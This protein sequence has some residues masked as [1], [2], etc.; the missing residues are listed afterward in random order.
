MLLAID[1]GNTNT[2]FGI[3]RGNGTWNACWRV[4][5]FRSTVGNDWAPTIT[6]LAHRDGIDLQAIEDVCICSVVP[7]ATTALSEFAR[8]W[9]HIESMLVT[10]DKALNITLGMD[11]P[12][13]V[14][15]DRIANAVAAWESCRTACIVIDMGTAT[16]VEAITDDG[17][18]AGG[19]IAI[20]V[21]TAMDALIARAARLYN[22]ELKDPDTAIG[23]NTVEALQAGIVRGHRHSVTG[24]VQ[25][26]RLQIALDSPV[27]VT[28]G[29]AARFRD[30]MGSLAQYEPNLTLDGVRLIHGLNAG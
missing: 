9:L 21:G 14:G 18:F 24:R 17:V 23:R 7:A 2:V 16:K 10:A 3:T 28:G 6:A 15:A 26:I 25:D 13:E 30:D 8:E 27:L 5:T 1:V 4:S 22:V 20:G 19:S 12:H 29:C 11:N